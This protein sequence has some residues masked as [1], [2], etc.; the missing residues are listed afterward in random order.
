MVGAK[1]MGRPFI[2]VDLQFSLCEESNRIKNFIENRKDESLFHSK[3][4]A[5]LL[6]RI[7]FTYHLSLRT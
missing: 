1:V 6:M 7:T 5:Y 3:R 2:V 4:C